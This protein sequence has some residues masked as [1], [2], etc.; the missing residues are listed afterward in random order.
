V[1]H[2]DP[3]TDGCECRRSVPAEDYTGAGFEHVVLGPM[4]SVAIHSSNR[5]RSTRAISNIG[6]GPATPR[7]FTSCRSEM[8]F[9]SSHFA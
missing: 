1:P 7:R 4:R 3:T 6:S 5:Y 2:R 9:I 8:D